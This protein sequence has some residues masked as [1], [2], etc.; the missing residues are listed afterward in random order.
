M[1]SRIQNAVE[2]IQQ[3]PESNMRAVAREFGVPRGRLR[4]RM[5]GHLPHRAVPAANTKLSRAEETA[6]CRYI[7]RLDGINLAV[8]AEFVTDAANFILRE[9][10]SKTNGESLP[11]VGHN[12]TTRFLKRHSYQKRMQKK[13]HM[14]RQASED[15]NRVAQYF[16]SIQTIIT[17]EGIPPQDIWNMDGR[18][19]GSA[20]AR[21]S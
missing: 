21:I 18:D 12:W 14:D 8:R 15:P 4:S 7:D 3:N 19:S 6:L 5:Q 13:V 16:Q 11:M 17:E 10:S 20:V 1:E 9:R 2:Y